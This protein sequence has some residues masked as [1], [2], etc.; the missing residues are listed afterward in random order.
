[1]QVWS[2]QQSLVQVWLYLQLTLTLPWIK[3]RTIM[4]KLWKKT[5]DSYFWQKTLC[6]SFILQRFAPLFCSHTILLEPP[7]WQHLP[8][9]NHT[10]IWDTFYHFWQWKH[11]WWRCTD[12]SHNALV[13][14]CWG[15]TVIFLSNVRI[16]FLQGCYC[17]HFILPFLDNVTLPLCWDHVPPTSIPHGTTAPITSPYIHMAHR[18]ADVHEKKVVFLFSSTVTAY[19]IH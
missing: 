15:W 18:L 5:F 13:E 11:P 3:T 12:I 9:W 2:E 6:H 19:S 10:L 16:L 17:R 7:L 4:K 1:M 8:K 14:T